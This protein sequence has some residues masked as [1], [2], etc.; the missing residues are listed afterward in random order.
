[1]RGTREHLFD[2]VGIHIQAFGCNDQILFAAAKIQV[3]FGVNLSKVARMQPL[4]FD[5]YAFATNENFSV[6]CDRDVLTRDDL[7]E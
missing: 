6:C 1:M 7:A 4:A 3:A 2:I 5:R